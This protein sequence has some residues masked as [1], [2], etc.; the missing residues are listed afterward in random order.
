M[1][2]HPSSITQFFPQEEML[3]ETQQLERLRKGPLE[4]TPL[5]LELLSAEADLAGK[6]GPPAD[7]V[8]S[9][10]WRERAYRF[11]V[12]CKGRSTPKILQECIAQATA[13]ADPPGTYP[14][15]MVPYLSPAQ[16]RDLEA[17]DISAI[18]ACGNGIIVIPGELL[19]LKTGQPN[20]YPDSAPL[21]NPYRG[22]SSLVA[23]AFLLVPE[24]DQ[25][26]DIRVEIEA[27]AGRLGLPTVSKA[28]RRLE[29]DLIVGRKTGRIRLLQPEKL[30]EKLVESYQPPSV[31]GQSI[32][33]C[34]IEASGEAMEELQTIARRKNLELILTGVSSAEAYGVPVTMAP[35]SL[36]SSDVRGVVES[37]GDRFRETSRF[38]NL[39]LVETRDQLVYFDPRRDADFP[40]ASPIQTYL[41]LMAGDK[42]Q[43]EVAEQVKRRI[44]KEMSDAQTDVQ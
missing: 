17:N 7:A 8:L 3:S 39:E 2:E 27:R 28:L 21:K 38:P 18:D 26:S 10:R 9:V 20:R 14:M 19:V 43:R 34:T 41:E 35:Y 42:R 37:L 31:S 6:P 24:F 13:Y 40:W 12:E 4:F 30:L 15:I 16:L 36:Y 25:V 33:K 44:L 1:L 23:R 32:G 5:V 11:V 22:V 29:D